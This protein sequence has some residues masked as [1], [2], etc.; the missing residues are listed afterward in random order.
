[1]LLQVSFKYFAKYQNC[2]DKSGELIFN[3]N[4]DYFPDIN[5]SSTFLT[6]SGIFKLL[7]MLRQE[8]G[9]ESLYFQELSVKRVKDIQLLLKEI[10]FLEKLIATNSE[11]LPANKSMSNQESLEIL[12]KVTELDLDLVY[13]LNDIFEV[14]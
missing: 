4:Y 14:K 7:N 10:K 5:T 6:P 12:K 13:N 3:K 11:R 2:P 1:M 8:V 9:E